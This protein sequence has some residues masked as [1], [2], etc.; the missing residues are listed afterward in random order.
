MAGRQVRVRINEAQIKKF[1][2]AGGQ[3]HGAVRRL[4]AVTEVV[5]RQEA[6]SRTGR[7]KASISAGENWSNGRQSRFT[8]RVGASYASYVLDGVRGWI[9][10]KHRARNRAGNQ[11][12]RRPG[13]FSGR[14]PRFPV[15]KSQGEPQGNWTMAPKVRGQ[16]A[17][18]FL[19]RAVREVMRR[20]GYL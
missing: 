18:N 20:Q 10:P 14:P 3:V 11:A 1:T 5:A 15:G 4:S 6:P 12:G 19:M 7:M 2:L 13:T 16:R 9:Y 8:V 17:N